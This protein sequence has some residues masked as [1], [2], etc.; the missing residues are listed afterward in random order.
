MTIIEAIMLFVAA[1]LAGALNAVAGG[2]SFI[3]FPA[4]VFTGVPE[5]AANATNTVIL[6]PGAVASTGAYR[7]E[8]VSERTLTVLLS[9]ISLLGGLAGAQLLLAFQDY[10]E[11]FSALVPWLLLAATLLFAFGNRATTW[12]RSRINLREGSRS[13]LIVA[14]VMQFFIAIYGGFFGGGM[15][16]L[17]L[18]AFALI[19]MSNIHTMNALKS[20]VSVLIKGIAVVAFVLAG[21]VVWPEAVVMII[22]AIIGG[23][24]GADVARRF[25][26]AAVRQFIIVAAWII[27]AVFFYRT[28]V[29]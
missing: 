3:T 7:R 25:D 18:A 1:V 10:E 13:A 12:L 23:Y 21:I 4:L 24:W 11:A 5:I 14:S 22:G 20:L 16:V 15:G 2:G 17:M 29:A 28:Y 19:G 26:Q 27:T 6:W 9:I 8:L